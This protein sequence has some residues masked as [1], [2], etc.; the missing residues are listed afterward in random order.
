MDSA[1]KRRRVL[2]RSEHPE[3][4]GA[5][6]GAL[7]GSGTFDS[8]ASPAV[9]TIRPP[10]DSLAVRGMGKAVREQVEALIHFA[11]PFVHGRQRLGRVLQLDLVTAYSAAH[12][13]ETDEGKEELLA[14]DSTFFRH[15][16]V[17]M[18][19][20]KHAADKND[21]E[22][23][24]TERGRTRVHYANVSLERC[25]ELRPESLVFLQWCI[26]LRDRSARDHT[27][28]SWKALMEQWNSAPEFDP[29]IN[30]KSLHS[31]GIVTIAKTRPG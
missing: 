15:C 25:M 12:T 30:V 9:R 17:T 11:V 8:T 3:N 23:A 31:M 24:L 18:R 21:V 1:H 28:V 19:S 13:H 10:R 6:A 27:Q 4:F 26:S 14:R 29:G 16:L 2:H 5:A 7:H 20:I 22:Y